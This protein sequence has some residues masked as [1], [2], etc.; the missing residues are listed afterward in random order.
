MCCS[1]LVTGV[2]TEV[3]F[4][5]GSGCET[6]GE[7]RYGYGVGGLREGGEERDDGER[8]GQ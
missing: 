8:C 4:W 2:R 3:G 7:L 1:T 5:D 6:Y